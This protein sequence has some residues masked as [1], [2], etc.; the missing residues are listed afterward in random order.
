MKIL[1][2]A[3]Y[4]Y[5]H[6]G[7]VEQYALDL[8]KILSKSNE[9][10]IVCPNTEKVEE[11]EYVSKIRVLRLPAHDLLHIF[12]LIYSKKILKELLY[13]ENFDLIITNTRLFHTSIIGTKIAKEYKIPQIHVEHGSCFFQTKEPITFLLSRAYDHSIGNWI[14]KSATKIVCVSQGSKK[15]VESLTKRKD[16]EVIFN[17]I[18]LTNLPPYKIKNELKK[19]VYAGRLIYGKG[20]QDLIR[21]F[22]E[23]KGENV[24][25]TL[26]GEGQYRKKLIELTNRLGIA[27]KVNFVGR[28]DRLEVLRLLSKSDLFVN[29]SYSEGLPTTVLEAGAIGLPVIATNVGGTKELILNNNTGILVQQ[30]NPEEIRKA[31]EFVINNPTK[32]A[33]YAKNL[34]KLIRSKFDW[35]VLAQ[36]WKKLIKKV[37]S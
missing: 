37:Q 2:F 6:K 32:R 22:S 8:A 17:G 29:P 3:G 7:G 5:P 35:E 15:F 18:S 13:G 26:I 12:P 20:V 16:I 11:K 1:I 14:L 4:F 21:A 31:L 23:L 24:N 30:K 10:T 25:L 27:K 28:K 9:V 34:N 33:T 36:K 19:I